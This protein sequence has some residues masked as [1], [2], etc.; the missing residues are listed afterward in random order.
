[1]PPKR[2]NRVSHQTHRTATIPPVQQVIDA[3][4]VNENSISTDSTSLTA[5][6][7]YRGR[8]RA[9][10]LIDK[11]TCDTTK[12]SYGSCMREFFKWLESKYPSTVVNRGDSKSI[13]FDVIDDDYIMEYFGV[14]E[15]MD[16]DCIENSRGSRVA[17]QTMDSM[18]TALSDHYLKNGNFFRRFTNKV[19]CFIS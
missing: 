19:K 4:N 2:S 16:S 14:F 7:S 13:N 15:Y 5:D 17:Y 1:M 9:S 3:Q 6:T 8:K 18:H 11:H 12:D 10:D